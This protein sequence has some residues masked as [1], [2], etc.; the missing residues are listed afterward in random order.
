MHFQAQ[1]EKTPNHKNA[2]KNVWLNLVEHILT[3]VHGDDLHASHHQMVCAIFAQ[4]VYT[5]LFCIPYR[6]VR[7][8]TQSRFTF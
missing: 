5:Y 2:V 8:P 7:Q 6:V 3:C 1:E 4:G